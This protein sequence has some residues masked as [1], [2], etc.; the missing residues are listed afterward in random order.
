MKVTKNIAPVLA[1]VACAALLGACDK[2]KAA[3]DAAPKISGNAIT[4]AVDQPQL[5]G[6]LTAPVEP[7]RE[8]ELVLPGRL[9]WDE[10]RTV[11]VFTPFAG[12]VSKLVAKVGD[13]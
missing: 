4:Y 7:P 11:R 9:T 10:D 6:I 5:K 1:A 12:R 3:D 13:R 2:G 8:R